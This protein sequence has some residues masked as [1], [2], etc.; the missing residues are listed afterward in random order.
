[1]TA[2]DYDRGIYPSIDIDAIRY[3]TGRILDLLHEGYS[4]DQVISHIS[5]RPGEDAGS[6]YDTTDAFQAAFIQGD[7]EESNMRTIVSGENGTSENILGSLTFCNYFLNYLEANSSENGDNSCLANGSILRADQNYTTPLDRTVTASSDLYRIVDSSEFTASTVTTDVGGG[8]STSNLNA[9]AGDN[10]PEQGAAVAAKPVDVT[11]PDENASDTASDI[12]A[13]EPAPSDEGSTP[14]PTTPDMEESPA[15]PVIPDV[16]EPVPATPAEPEMP[17]SA[18][19]ED[20]EF[21]P[22][23]VVSEGE[24]CTILPHDEDAM[25]PE[26]DEAVAEPSSEPDSDGGNDGGSDDSGND[27]GGNDGGGDDAGD[28]ADDSGDSGE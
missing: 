7:D 15:I 8:K 27:D 18:P 17:S 11:I 19:A 23:Q 12:V 4:L 25:V 13:S 24:Q 9:E 28:A 14:A 6:Y 26:Y 20:P 21:I 22:D 5:L 2:P 10:D 16:I 3:G 1:M